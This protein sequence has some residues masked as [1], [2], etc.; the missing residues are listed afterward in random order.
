MYKDHDEGRVG[1]AGQAIVDDI[2]KWVRGIGL[3]WP[4]MHWTGVTLFMI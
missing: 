2:M 3:D 4:A 1:Y